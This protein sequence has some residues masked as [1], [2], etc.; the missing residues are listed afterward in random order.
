MMLRH[1]KLP[2][3]SDVIQDSV[4]KTL[5]E[6]KVR[7]RDIGGNNTIDEFTREILSNVR[8]EEEAYN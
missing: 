4:F 8:M 6:G 2:F 7:T 5:K 3:F 1:L